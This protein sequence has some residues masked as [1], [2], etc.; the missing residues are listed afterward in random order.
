MVLARDAAA[1]TSRYYPTLA[2]FGLDPREL[3]LEFERGR[4][5][6]VLFKLNGQRRAHAGA[7]HT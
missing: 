3:S 2:F 1:A 6:I 4:I 5:Q 7:L